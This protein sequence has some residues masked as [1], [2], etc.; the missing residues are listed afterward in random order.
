M[1]ADKEE[2]KLTA[3]EG[4]EIW[5]KDTSLEGSGPQFVGEKKILSI[6]LFI[7]QKILLV[8]YFEIKQQ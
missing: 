7:F 3:A 2:E 5:I 6:Y 4:D 8:M 1:P